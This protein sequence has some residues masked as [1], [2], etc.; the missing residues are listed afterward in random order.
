MFV[1]AMLCLF[2]IKA[3]VGVCVCVRK[4]KPPPPPMSNIE[5]TEEFRFSITALFIAYIH[6]FDKTIEASAKRICFSC[7]LRWH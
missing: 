1:N 4:K 5:T 2:C 6:S 7:K 3:R